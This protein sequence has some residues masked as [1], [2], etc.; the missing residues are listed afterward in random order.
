MPQ[1]RA[2]L[3]SGAYVSGM[4]PASEQLVAHDVTLSGC[5]IGVLGGR[6]GPTPD[7]DGHDG[8]LASCA[9]DLHQEVATRMLGVELSVSGRQAA[10]PHEHAVDGVHEAVTDEGIVAVARG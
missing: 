7:F 2:T 1:T 4:M 6:A 3:A 8:R 5:E 10:H 9:R